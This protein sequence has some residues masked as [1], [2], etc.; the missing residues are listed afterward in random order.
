MHKIIR[1]I[2]ASCFL[3]AAITLPVYAQRQ[4]THQTTPI[5]NTATVP[6]DRWMEIDLYWF[7]RTNLQPSVKE[8]WDRFAP[9]Y[10]GIEGDR[11]LILN[12]GWTVEYIM[13]WDGDLQQVMHLPQGTGQQPWVAETS[14]LSGTTEGRMAAWKDRFSKPIMVQKKGYGPWTY[15]DVKQ[16]RELLRAEGERRGIHDFK[17]G[18]LVYAWDNAYGEIAPWV[19]RHPEA[20]SRN[21]PGSIQN[22]SGKWRYFDPENLLHKDDSKLGGLPGG[23]TE[24]MPAYHVFAEQWGSMSKAVGLDALILRDSIGFPIPYV[25]GGTEG[26]VA[27]SPEKIRLATEAVSALVRETKQANPKS[28]VM[29]YSNAA[30]AVS[31][32]RSNGCDL[33]RIAKEGYLD[34]FV[35][36]TWAG[37]W[38]EVGVRHNNFWNSPLLGWTYQLG[39]TLVHAA[40]LADT[41]VKHYPLIETFDAWESWDVL[42]TV[43]QRLRWGIWAYSHAGV[44]SPHGMVMPQGSYISWANQGKRLLTQDDVAFLANNIGEAVRDAAQVKDIAG[45]TIVYSRSAMQYEIDHATSQRTAKEWIDETAETVAKWPVPVLS[46]TRSEWLADIHTDLALV[47]TPGHLSP[48]ETSAVEKRISGGL[49]TALIGDFSNGMSGKWTSA[50]SAGGYGRAESFSVAHPAKSGDLSGLDVVGVP[51]SFNTATIFNK[52]AGRVTTDGRV[53]YSIGDAPQLVVWNTPEKK[54][55]MWDPPVLLQMRKTPLVTLMG[56]SSA[57]YVAAAGAFNSLLRDTGALHAKSI[58]SQ[59]TM[60]AAAWLT[61]DGREHLLFG[62]LEEGLRN[63]SDMTRHATILLPKSMQSAWTAQ[64]AQGSSSFTQSGPELT[65]QLA[66][67]ASMLLTSKGT[68]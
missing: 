23:I 14:P 18:S 1:R 34:I 10:R 63:D 66:P 25:R 30:S 3:A 47:Q 33:E 31:D 12:I 9:L 38:N 44:K 2:A 21:V 65:V 67:V 29:M 27:S 26:D 62:N 17:V 58:D 24:G 64:W 61:R 42:H 11:G 53:V 48:A 16:F 37:A 7:D 5:V 51:T 56:G 4:G 52:P 45:P 41:K 8:F 55:A 20:F 39:Y 43:P 49:P 35:D 32:W 13:Q 57:A 59:Q 22:Y 54:L 28:L 6:G 68:K 60:A 15:A 19:K 50:V 36:Q 46:A 40:M